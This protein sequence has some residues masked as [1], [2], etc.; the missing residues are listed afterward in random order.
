[1]QSWTRALEQGEVDAALDGAPATLIMDFDGT[2]APFVPHPPDARPYEGVVERL[3]RLAA[4]GC[5]LVF[6]TGRD[7]R[8][9][10][11][12]LGLAEPPEVWGS[13]GGER[14]TPDGRIRPLTLP[15]EQDRGLFR[16]RSWA[17]SAGY[18]L[19]AEPKPGGLSLHVR[20]MPEALR[21]DVLS[22]V[23]G[24]WAGIA[25]EH[26]LELRDFDGGLEL[27]SPAVHKGLAVA[28]IVQESS[29]DRAIFYLG[30]D[31]TDEDAFAALGQRGLSLLVRPERRDSRALWW[32]RPPEELLAFLDRL[33][34]A[35]AG[36]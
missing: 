11:P 32:L 2:L 8:D 23:R 31:E 34:Q 19:A 26:G 20:A 15:P 17:V 22:R 1:M 6:V 27:R 13:H 21:A 14:L 4:M 7:C 24:T 28:A 9:L 12:L 25:A 5:R 33:I 16:A 18:S 36:R 29:W 3:D 30:D 10:P 35:G